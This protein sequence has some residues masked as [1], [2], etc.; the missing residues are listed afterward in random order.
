MANAEGKREGQAPTTAPTTGEAAES[1]TN[2][3]YGIPLEAVHAKE[4]GPILEGRDDYPFVG[5]LYCGYRAGTDELRRSTQRLWY[6]R[7]ADVLSSGPVQDFVVDGVPVTY[8]EL[9]VG[10]W[11]QEKTFKSVGLEDEVSKEDIFAAQA[12][13]APSADAPSIEAM[14]QMAAAMVGGGP[15]GLGGGLELAAWG[16]TTSTGRCRTWRQTYRTTRYDPWSRSDASGADCEYE[17]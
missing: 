15:G 6:L 11:I 7:K 9:E 3:I 1:A 10:A 2:R 14:R 16:G 4:L 12:A 5:F 8:Y 13:V 17:D